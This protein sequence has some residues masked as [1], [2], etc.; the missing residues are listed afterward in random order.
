M[1]NAAFTLTNRA[2]F[3]EQLVDFL[4]DAGTDEADMPDFNTYSDL[5]VYEFAEYVGYDACQQ[6]LQ[7]VP[8][9]A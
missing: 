4:F 7:V 9:F 2:Q 5:D 3:L 6:A 8:A 1:T